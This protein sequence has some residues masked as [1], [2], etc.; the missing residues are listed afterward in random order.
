LAS[1]LDLAVGRGGVH[2]TAAA[3]KFAFVVRDA[4]RA[5]TPVMWGRFPYVACMM[6]AIVGLMCGLD[7][8]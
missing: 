7:G 3:G 1:A 4:R 6:L 5:M 8:R 2:Q